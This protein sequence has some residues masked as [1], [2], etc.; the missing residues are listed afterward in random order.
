MTYT[1]EN[2]CW[3]NWNVASWSLT[4]TEPFF[5]VTNAVFAH[6]EGSAKYPYVTT[7]VVINQKNIS[8]NQ[9]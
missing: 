8:D 1:K 6:M 3:T 4:S 7:Q 2:C 5:A 9:I